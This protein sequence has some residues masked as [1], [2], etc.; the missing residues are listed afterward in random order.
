MMRGED[1]ARSWTAAPS[2]RARLTLGPLHHCRPASHHDAA[3]RR[4]QAALAL[5][6]LADGL[7][8]RGKRAQ[9]EQGAI[10]IVDGD[11]GAR[12]VVVAALAA[13]AGGIAL[14]LLALR[15]A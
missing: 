1:G 3:A 10:P 6:L 13:L 5:E 4:D 7:V 9:Q 2:P 15:C 11:L 12:A 8:L 14:G